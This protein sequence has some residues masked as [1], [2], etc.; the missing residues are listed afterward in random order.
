MS[1]PETAIPTAPSLRVVVGS[2]TALKVQAVRSAFEVALSKADLRA[3][4]AAPAGSD[5]AEGGLR[6]EGV[7]AASGINEQPFGHEETARGAMSRLRHAKELAPGADFY[8]SVEN[9]LFEVNVDGAPRFFDLAWVAVERASDGWS[10]LAHSVGLEFERSWVE[11]ARSAGKGF[12]ENTVGAVVAARAPEGTDKQDPHA[13][14][15]GGLRPRQALLQEAL[16]AA[17]GPLLRS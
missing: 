1:E 14:L 9:G 8:A 6:V 4:E 7:K 10:G 5:D 12:E 11:E 2:A 16:L 3:P 15:T 17:M 13:W